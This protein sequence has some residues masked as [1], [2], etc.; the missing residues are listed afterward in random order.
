[1]ESETFEY[2]YIL[3]FLLD[4]DMFAL[5]LTFRSLWLLPVFLYFCELAIRSEERNNTKI[6]WHY[7][8]Q[9]SEIYKNQETNA[10]KPIIE[11]GFKKT[12]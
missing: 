11:H 4:S 5:T 12:S 7:F 3:I 10:C 9:F 6:K 8:T 2:E 1:M